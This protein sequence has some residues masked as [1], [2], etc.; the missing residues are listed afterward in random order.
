MPHNKCQ[1]FADDVSIFSVVDN[2]NLS[3]T[4]LNSDLNKIDALLIKYSFK[5][6]WTFI[7]ALNWT[8][9]NILKTFSKR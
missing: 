6:T 8:F 7:W 4:N 9:V 1:A 5:I 2:I 3:A